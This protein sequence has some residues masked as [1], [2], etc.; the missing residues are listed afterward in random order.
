MAEIGTRPWS[1]QYEVKD[2]TIIAETPDLRALHITLAVG[3]VIP[4]HFHS[5]VTENFTCAKG[6][7]VVETKAPRDRHRLEAGERLKLPPRTAH[8]V[9]NGGGGDCCFVL[10][11][12]IGPYDFIPA[13]K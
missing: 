9:S 2:T 7:L 13:G 10:V 12:G 5:H 4:W 3:D 11:Q 1:S 6:V 8:R